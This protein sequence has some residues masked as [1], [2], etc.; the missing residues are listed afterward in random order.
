MLIIVCEMAD[1]YIEIYG[2]MVR[3]LVSEAKMMDPLLMSHKLKLLA[4]LVTIIMNLITR[5]LL[6]LILTKWLEDQK[7]GL[8]ISYLLWKEKEA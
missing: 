1:V 6:Y 7:L 5:R 4:C 8:T 3:R 2:F